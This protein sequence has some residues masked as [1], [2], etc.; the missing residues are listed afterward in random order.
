MWQ[1][2][3]LFMKMSARRWKITLSMKLS[4]YIVTKSASINISMQIISN[5]I[6]ILGLVC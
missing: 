3:S 2:T 5:V 6:E 1:H 4:N